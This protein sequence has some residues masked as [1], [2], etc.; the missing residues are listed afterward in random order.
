MTY[1][2]VFHNEVFPKIPIGFSPPNKWWRVSPFIYI[3]V[4]HVAH[5]AC[6]KHLSLEAS[7]ISGDSRITNTLPETNIAHENPHL[8]R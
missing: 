2:W 7:Q 4:A 8:S 6:E 5:V 1:I 3:D